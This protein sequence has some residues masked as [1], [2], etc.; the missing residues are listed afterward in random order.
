MIHY[1]SGKIWILYLK[2]NV[3]VLEMTISL[4]IVMNAATLENIRGQSP[5]WMLPPSKIVILLFS[6]N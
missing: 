6:Y 1:F 2:N 3:G 4:L 5:K